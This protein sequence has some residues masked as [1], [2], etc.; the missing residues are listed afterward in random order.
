MRRRKNKEKI[1]EVIQVKLKDIEE[2]RRRMIQYILP[3]IIVFFIILFL[4][5]F[6]VVPAMLKP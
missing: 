6:F 2:A 4:F 5:A 3:A 1:E